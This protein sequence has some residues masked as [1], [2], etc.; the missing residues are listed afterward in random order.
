MRKRK[1]LAVVLT[2]L[3]SSAP[4]FANAKACS[5]SM[6]TAQQVVCLQEQ[7]AVLQQQLSNAQIEQTLSKI[8]GGSLARNLG[9][10]SV[11]AIFGRAGHLHAMLAWQD[12]SGASAGSLDVSA[13][14]VLPGG[15]RVD[16][17]LP[18]RVL[19]SDGHHT[20]V[21]LMSGGGVNGTGSTS[22]PPAGAL[23]ASIPPVPAVPAVPGR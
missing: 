2:A 15:L 16:K 6:G 7:N 4:A 12:A 14:A 17:I 13:G 10:P 21:L 1:V 11:A 3:C 5:S 8:D 18:G 9:L 19:L 23:G 20:H 22:A